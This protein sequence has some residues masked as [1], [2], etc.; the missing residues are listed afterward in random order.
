MP[1]GLSGKP[2]DYPY[3]GSI[4]SGPANHIS[5]ELAEAIQ[6]TG[7]AFGCPAWAL[8]QWN[9]APENPYS[10]IGSW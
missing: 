3:Q 8:I 9:A 10:D 4:Y 1:E 6:Q 5:N 7:K 2:A